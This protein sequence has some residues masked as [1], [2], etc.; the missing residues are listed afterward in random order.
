VHSLLRLPNAASVTWSADARMHAL[1]TCGQR[2][3]AAPT[4]ARCVRSVCCLARPRADPGPA[5]AQVVQLFDSW[6]HHLSPDQYAEFSL[7][8]AERVVAAVRAARPGVPLIYH[9]NGGAPWQ[10]PV[11]PFY[12]HAVLFRRAPVLM[13][14]SWQP[15]NL[16]LGAPALQLPV[17][18]SSGHADC[19]RHAPAFLYPLRAPGN[20]PTGAFGSKTKSWWCAAGNL[21]TRALGPHGVQLATSQT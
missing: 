5:R 1:H 20:L 12:G 7:P 13:A 2:G 15:P 18:P 11:F 4:S 19:F 8:Y 16:K 3:Q 9:A 21:I 14:C 17:F 10:P 6:A